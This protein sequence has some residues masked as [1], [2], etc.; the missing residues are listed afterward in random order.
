[1]RRANEP[2]MLR[3]IPK[4]VLKIGPILKITIFDFY[5]KNLID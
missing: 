3:K 2:D 4:V 1:L 5:G